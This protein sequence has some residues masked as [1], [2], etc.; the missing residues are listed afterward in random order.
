MPPAARLSTTVVAILNEREIPFN[1]AVDR[2][3]AQVSY[4]PARD[5][6]AVTLHAE[7]V[8]AQRGGDTPVHSQLDASVGMGRDSAHL[9]SLTLLSRAE[10][11]GQ[12]HCCGPAER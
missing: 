5:V 4:V 11:K 3:A 10:G 1:L 2:L 7:D 6:Y 12:K 9:V 8:D